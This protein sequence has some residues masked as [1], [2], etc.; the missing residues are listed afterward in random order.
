MNISSLP[1][2]TVNATDANL[3][4]PEVWKTD[5][6]VD[7]RLPY[8]LIGTAEFL[9][10]KTL[11][12]LRYVDVNL[13]GPS[14]NLSGPDNRVSFKT[15]PTTYI[16][17]A[18][19][20]VY[21][22]KNT[23]KGDSWTA[24]LKL[25]KPTT[26]GFGGM[27]GYTLGQARDIQ[28][29]ASTVLANTPTT[30]GQNNLALAYADN[31]LRHRIVSYLNYRIN[32]GGEFGGS[33]MFTLG[34]VSASGAKFSYTYSQDLN[35][36]KQ[37]N[38]LIFVPQKATDLT[39]AP[40]TVGTGANAVT[41]TPQQQADALDAFI[42]KNPYLK[43]RRGQYAERNGGYY[44]WLTRYDFSIVQEIYMKVNG[45]KNTLQLR[46][47]ILNIGNLFNNGLGASYNATTTTPL[48]VASVTAGVPTYKAAA[49]VMNSPYSFVKS[50]NVNNAWQAQIGIRYIFN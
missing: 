50:V 47:D 49:A 10:N 29:V 13:Q 38:D 17:S 4:F 39:F 40:L 36:D 42:D 46:C 18:V 9:Y 8:G 31:D 48:S 2:Y 33:T 21:V 45:K 26:K 23:T 20:S 14:S 1:P 27:I 41:Y 30:W 19:Q 44:P 5:I 37:V 28:S 11:Q 32:Y 25:E 24:T 7:Q 16:N 22:L 15:N 34:V 6:A 43:N 35:G 3:K 12:G